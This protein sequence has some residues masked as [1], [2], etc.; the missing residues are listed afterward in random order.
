[1]ILSEDRVQLNCSLRDAC[2]C[3]AYLRSSHHQ[4]RR[5]ILFFSFLVIFQPFPLLLISVNNLSQYVVYII[6]FLT[7]NNSKQFSRATYSPQCFCVSHFLPPFSLVISILLRVM[8]IYKVLH[9]KLA[10]SPCQKSF[11][12]MDN[13]Y[14]KQQLL[15]GIILRLS[16][17]PPSPYR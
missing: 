1:M 5:H 8:H 10:S 7:S 12:Q 9:I 15:V 14:I 11:F 6:F 13:K 2:S 3:P 4:I 17:S 16:L